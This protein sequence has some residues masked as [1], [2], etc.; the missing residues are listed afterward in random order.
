[1][2]A[3]RALKIVILGQLD[4]R[5]SWTLKLKFNFIHHM[6]TNVKKVIRQNNK[7]QDGNNTT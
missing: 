5:E 1:M 6:V 2:S 3:T 7:G 4:K